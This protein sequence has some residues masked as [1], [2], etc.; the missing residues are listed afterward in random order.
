VSWLPPTTTI[1]TH[2]PTGDDIPIEERDGDEVLYAWGWSD[3]GRFIRVRT[4]PATST[5]RNPAF[6]VTPA[7]LITG[8]VTERGIIPATAEGIASVARRA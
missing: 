5:A 3:E 7:E 6:D 2:T 1:A 8:I 4:S